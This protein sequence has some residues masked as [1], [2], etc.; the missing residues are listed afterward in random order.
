MKRPTF[1]LLPR[2]ASLRTAVTVG[3]WQPR[4]DACPRPGPRLESAKARRGYLSSRVFE[5]PYMYDT[6][7]TLVTM[8]SKRVGWP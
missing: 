7:H 6:Y 8:A 5:G 2:D 1:S 4:L 3:L